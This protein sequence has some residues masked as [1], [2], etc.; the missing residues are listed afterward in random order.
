MKINQLCQEAATQWPAAIKTIN[1]DL[2]DGVRNIKKIANKFRNVCIVRASAFNRPFSKKIPLNFGTDLFSLRGD[3]YDL[4]D[5]PIEL[6]F[7]C[8]HAIE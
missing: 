4:F 5:A 1:M 6:R 2:S 7:S 8:R 3:L